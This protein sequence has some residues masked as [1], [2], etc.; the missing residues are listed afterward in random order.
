[1]IKPTLPFNEIY[2]LQ[3]LHDL[4]ILD[5][6]PEERFDRII[7]LAIRLFDVP[8]A[9][10][11]LVDANRQWFKSCYGLDISESSRDISFCAHAILADDILLIP[12]A[13]ADERFY[14]NPFVTNDPFIRFYAGCPLVGLDGNKLGTLCIIDRRPR[15]FSQEDLA[16]LRDLAKM[17]EKELM[18][19]TLDRAMLTIRD[20][21]VQKHQLLEEINSQKELTNT[22]FE[23]CAVAVVVVNTRHQVI[24]WN[25]A[26]EELTGYSSSQM[27]ASSDQWKPFYPYSRQLLPTSLLTTTTSKWPLSMATRF[28]R[29]R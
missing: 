29:L 15:E 16:S 2:R 17:V 9:L 24:L 27:L 28:S 23:H 4:K 6:P 8:I 14:D 13:L 5:T 25:K 18:S 11:S 19:A 21:E 20:S 7:R 26:A 1:M 12:D 10:V 3:A 22:L